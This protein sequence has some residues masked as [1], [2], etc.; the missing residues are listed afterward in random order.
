MD[1]SKK[2]P[3]QTKNT[4]RELIDNLIDAQE[5]LQKIGESLK[6]ES[7]KR[8]LLAE[9]LARAEFRG[10]LENILHQV[11][12]PDVDESGTAVGKLLRSWSGLKLKVGGS[13]DQL[14][15]IA[16]KEEQRAI[17]A[18]HQALARKLPRDVEEVLATHVQRIVASHKAIQKAREVLR[19]PVR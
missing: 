10:E 4:L 11:G 2:I 12:V 13:D 1:S 15:E 6:D 19:Q 5:G 9:S 17:E 14:L 7:I 16:E 3:A 18:Y 8:V